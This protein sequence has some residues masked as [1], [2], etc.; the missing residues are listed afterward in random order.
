MWKQTF[1]EACF[2]KGIKNKKGNCNLSQNSAFI[3]ATCLY[4]FYG[5]ALLRKKLYFFMFGQCLNVVVLRVLREPLDEHIC[6][7][8]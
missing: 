7:V 2:R 4:T 5:T 8:S 6:S 1:L 3:I